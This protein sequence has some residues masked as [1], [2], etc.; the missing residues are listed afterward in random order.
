L[1]LDDIAAIHGDKLANDDHCSN[2][3]EC[4]VSA[5]MDIYDEDETDAVQYDIHHAV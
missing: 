1:D 2:P 5:M 4:T 3:D